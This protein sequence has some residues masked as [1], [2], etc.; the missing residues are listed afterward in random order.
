MKSD[1]I[2]LILSIRT[3]I[4]IISLIAISPFVNA[5]DLNKEV[6]V[7]SSFQPEIADADKLGFMPLIPDTFSMGTTIDYTL[8]PSKLKSDFSLRPIKPAKMVGTPLDRLYNSQLRLGIGNYL[9]PLI[10]YN[11]QNLRSKE[12]TIGAYAYHKSSHTTIDIDHITNIPA[13]YGHNELF[14]YGKRFYKDINLFAEAGATSRKLRFYGLNTGILADT[15]DVERR[16]IRQS[17]Y[18]I[19]GK[20]GLYSTQPDSN[21]LQYSLALA[22]NYFW[23]HFKNKEPHFDISGSLSHRINTFQ[24]G[25]EI[26]YNN[27]SLKNSVDTAKQSV[28]SFYPF[29]RKSKDEWQ[30]NLGIRVD[31]LNSTAFDSVYFYPEASIRIRVI[32]NAMFGF[33]GI[34]G[35]LEQNSYQKLTSENPYLIPGINT[36]NTNHP[37]IVYGGLEGYLSSKASYKVDISTHATQDMIFFINSDSTALQNQFEIVTDDADFIKLHGEINWEPLSY[38]SFYLRS[39]YYKYKVYALDKP[40]HRPAI[41]FLLTTR[42]NFKEKVYVDLDFISFGKRYASDLN[43]GRTITLDPIYDINLKLEYKY[44]NVLS[45]FLHFYNL[46]TK[47]YYLWNQYPVQRLNVLGGISYKF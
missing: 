17:F 27:F 21:K 39:N 36:K 9:T 46:T 35:Y 11:I 24:I 19:H 43:S 14:G 20:A 31:V 45:I 33:V 37:F 30:V 12:Y 10:E 34:T 26:A 41:E 1:H 18:N 47:E 6:Y 15:F 3:L 29:L 2:Q 44:S 28:L 8:L 16:D 7:V 4:S 13:G 32:E 22:G 38:L 42:F 5:Q 40:W 25:V 23:D